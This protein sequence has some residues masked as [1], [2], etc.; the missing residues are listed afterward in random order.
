MNTLDIYLKKING[1]N[2]KYIQSISEK[3]LLDSEN[4]T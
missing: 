1:K 3:G 4:D 2:E